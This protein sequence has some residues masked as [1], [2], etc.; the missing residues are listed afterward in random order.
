MYVVA[1]EHH[2]TDVRRSLHPPHSDHHHDSDDHHDRHDQHD[3]H[4]REQDGEK[5]A[6]TVR[7]DQCFKILVLHDHTKIL[8]P[9]GGVGNL[10]LHASHGTLLLHSVHGSIPR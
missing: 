7:S 4:D 5:R 9:V 3:P 8:R 1:L 10:F 6:K 2:A